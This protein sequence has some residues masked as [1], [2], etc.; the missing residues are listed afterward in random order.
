MNIIAQSNQPIPPIWG[1]N[2]NIITPRPPLLRRDVQST[3]GVLGGSIFPLSSFNTLTIS[4]NPS[5]AQTKEAFQATKDFGTI[6]SITLYHIDVNGTSLSFVEPIIANVSFDGNVY[7]CQN[8]DLG[9]LAIS[10]TLDD[11]VEDFKE[12]VLFVWNEYGK[13]TD[14]R[15]TDDAKELKRRILSHVNQSA[16]N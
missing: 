14:S 7:S 1:G 16:S 6:F 8:Q 2:Q 15:L 9:I 3:S 12:E 10:T 13:E 4:P 11:C 5:I